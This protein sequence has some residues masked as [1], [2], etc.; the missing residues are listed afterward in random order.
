MEDRQSLLFWNL[1]FLLDQFFKC[2]SLAQFIDQK[3]MSFRLEDFDE[4]DDIGMVYFSEDG[5]L[6]VGELLEFG[7][8]FELVQIHDFDSKE[9]WL[10][11]MFGFVYI[12][13]LTRA[14]L[15]FKDVV[16]DNLVH[17][18]IF[19][20]DFNIMQV[21]II[22]ELFLFWSAGWTS[23]GRRSFWNLSYLLSLNIILFTETFDVLWLN[24]DEGKQVVVN[25]G[26]FRTSGWWVDYSYSL[27]SCTVYPNQI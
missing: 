20:Y 15:L 8:L 10:C 9:T 7:C 17:I 27:R 12:S 11:F 16:L 26:L 19:E 14:Y 23:F 2:P 24:F 25:N 22:W 5:D 3:E 21:L 1:S 13:V 6:V 18:F 4:F